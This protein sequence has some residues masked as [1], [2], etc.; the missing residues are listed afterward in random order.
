MISHAPNSWNFYQLFNPKS[1]YC[2]SFMQILPSNS[3]GRADT[4][5]QY[6]TKNYIIR[7]WFSMFQILENFYPFLIKNHYIAIVLAIWTNKRKCRADTYI[8]A[9]ILRVPDNSCTLRS[10]DVGRYSCNDVTKYLLLHSFRLIC[11]L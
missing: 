8:H 10:F 7:C 6:V 5:I 11:H 9:C 2:N 3:E 1:L 4:Y